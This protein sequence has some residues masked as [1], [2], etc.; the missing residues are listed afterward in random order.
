MDWELEQTKHGLPALWEK[1]GA[2][3]N[4]GFARIIAG[5]N[6]APKPAVYINRRGELACKEHALI[7]VTAGDYIIRADQH[8]GDFEIDIYRIAA[9][10]H[11]DGRCVAEVNLAYQFSKGEWDCEPAKY[12]TTALKAA[13]NKAADYHCRH[14][15]YIKVEESNDPA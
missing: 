3:S 8:R 1:G 6:G 2:Y 15:Y 14:P 4:T 13:R 10:A 7:I 12:L 11:I 9:I 5:A